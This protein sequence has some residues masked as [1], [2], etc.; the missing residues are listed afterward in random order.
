MKSCIEIKNIFLGSN[1]RDVDCIHI[2]IPGQEFCSQAKE[3]LSAW[4]TQGIFLPPNVGSILPY[5]LIEHYL[6]SHNIKI[7]FLE[8]NIPLSL[9]NN[10]DADSRHI[11]H[12]F[13]GELFCQFKGFFLICS[14]FVP[15]KKLIYH[16]RKV[17][18]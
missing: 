15:V 17:A 9:I 5:L 7:T 11:T 10:D 1:S 12:F 13:S 16:I 3:F 6:H 8:P 18:R 14:H 4:S 2:V